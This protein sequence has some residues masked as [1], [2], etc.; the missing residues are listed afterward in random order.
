[1]SKLMYAE[2]IIADYSKMQNLTEGEK[3]LGRAC[4]ESDRFDSDILMFT[5]VIFL[6]DVKSLADA[7][8]KEGISEIAIVNSYS[9]LAEII[10]E[11]EDNGMKCEGTFR[12]SYVTEF[13]DERKYF[14]FKLSI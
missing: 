3:L 8:K 2:R 4:Y 7:L 14:G 11:L 5:Q 9:G 12:Y 10:C 6:E 1:M 13:K